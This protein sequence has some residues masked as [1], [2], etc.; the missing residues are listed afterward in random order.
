M[1]FNAMKQQAP[2]A[3]L[4]L[5]GAAALAP[6][7]YAT[8][9]QVNADLAPWIVL[10]AFVLAAFAFAVALFRLRGLIL[11]QAKPILLAVLGLT[12]LFLVS[13]SFFLKIGLGALAGLA[14]V[15]ASILALF[16][17]CAWAVVQSALGGDRRRSAKSLLAI[18]GFMVAVAAFALAW[19]RQSQYVWFWDFSTY[20]VLL[21]DL[22][23]AIRESGP[24]VGGLG[25][26]QNSIQYEYNMV[27]IAPIAAFQAAY[28]PFDRNF[29]VGGIAFLYLAPTL[30]AG[31]W[32]LRIVSGGLSGAGALLLICLSALVFPLVF[33]A[34]LYGMPDIGGVGLIA[35]ILAVALREGR[36][37]GESDDRVAPMIVCAGLLVLLC[38]FRR[39]Y[40]FAVPPLLA[41]LAIHEFRRGAAPE[42]FAR[43]RAAFKSMLLLGSFAGL[44]GFAFYWGRLL[45]TLAHNYPDAYRAWARPL[46]EEIVQAA[47]CFGYGPLA[48]FLACAVTLIFWRAT[49]WVG[50]AALAAPILIVAEFERVQG[51]SL[52]HYLLLQPFMIFAV[53]LAAATVLARWP[54]ARGPVFAGLAACAALALSGGHFPGAQMTMYETGLAPALSIAPPQ[55]GDLPELRR[56]TRDLAARAEAGD[57]ICVVASSFILNRSIIRE[58]AFEIGAASLTGDKFLWLGD[59]DRR[60]GFSSAIA[61]CDIAVLAD[62]LQTHLRREEQQLVVY[63][64]RALQSGSGLGASFSLTGASYRLDDGVQARLYRRTAPLAGEDL[65]AYAEAVEKKPSR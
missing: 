58:S 6:Y 55:R 32:L 10:A 38:I 12:P 16:C 11:A 44:C 18:L 57:K 62:P 59:V 34:P 48:L 64:A 1:A 65:R 43:L 14:L 33:Y 31:A 4:A 8:L 40:V 24:I 23:Q 9:R 50:L 19:L 46:D 29:L 49:R 2:V 63:L 3:G 21:R 39:W 35:T 30:L 22:S 36:G 53:A 54:L 41:I 28:G 17:A 51:F 25:V 45:A 60:D 20:A 27:P 37:Q 15:Q 7:Q 5:A 61:S 42:F 47:D 56:L 52:H 13:Q 26:V